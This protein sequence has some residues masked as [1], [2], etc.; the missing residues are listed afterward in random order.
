MAAACVADVEMSI[1]MNSMMCLVNF[2]KDGVEFKWYKDS[3]D[4]KFVKLCMG[5]FIVSF[6]VGL[7]GDFGYKY[8]FDDFEYKVVCLN[9]GDVLFFGGF[10]CMIV[11]SVLNVYLGLMFGYLCGKMFNGCLNV[12]VRDIGCGVID[13][14]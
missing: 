3:E 4:L 14:S 1:N 5:L 2:Y 6:F 7:S 13:V 8:S 9:L 10:L 11:Y 12:I